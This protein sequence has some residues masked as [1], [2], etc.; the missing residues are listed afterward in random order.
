MLSLSVH[1]NLL[2]RV[3]YREFSLKVLAVE[4]GHLA[5]CSGCKQSH[6]IPS[7]WRFNG[8]LEKPTFSPSLLIRYL[9]VVLDEGDNEIAQIDYTCHSFI[10]D[11]KWQYCSDSTHALAGQTVQMEDVD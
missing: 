3:I 5:Y 10:V 6:L 4:D 1:S 9:K 8:S 11:G 2:I 7:R